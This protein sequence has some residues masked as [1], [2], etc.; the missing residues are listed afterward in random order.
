MERQ[1]ISSSAHL[2]LHTNLLKKEVCQ[3]ILRFLNFR[4]GQNFNAH[5]QNHLP[6]AIPTWSTNFCLCSAHLLLHTNLLKEEVGQ[7][8]LR[9]L[10]LEWGQ[11]LNADRQNHLLRAIPM[12]S[13]NFFHALHISSFITIYCKNQRYAWEKP[14][15]DSKLL[16]ITTN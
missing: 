7:Y 14:S 9:F 10:N 2:P 13:A 8:L 6:M 11:N 1:F 12:R 5:R 3:Y 4:W 15:G 16:L